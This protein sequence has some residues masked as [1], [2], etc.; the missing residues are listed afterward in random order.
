MFL[1]V[2]EYVLVNAG[3]DFNPSNIYNY[4]KSNNY[5]KEYISE[6]VFIII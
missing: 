6:R 2:C 3:N 1:K 5:G 4:L